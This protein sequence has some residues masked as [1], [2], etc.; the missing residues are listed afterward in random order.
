MRIRGRNP[1]MALTE[2]EPPTALPRMHSMRRSR[3]LGSGLPCRNLSRGVDLKGSAH[4]GMAGV[5]R[6]APAGST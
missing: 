3:V 2:D 4:F 5:H 1:A 6:V